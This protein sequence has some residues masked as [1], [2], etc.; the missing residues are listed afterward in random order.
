[1][2]KHAASQTSPVEALG[3]NPTSPPTQQELFGALFSLFVANRTPKQQVHSGIIFRTYYTLSY[4]HTYYWTLSYRIKS[5][6]GHLTCPSL[7]LAT[8]LQNRV[9]LTIE[10]SKLFPFDHLAISKGGFAFL[11]SDFADVINTCQPSSPS[12]LTLRRPPPSLCISPARPADRI[13]SA[14]RACGGARAH[15]TSYA[16][17]RR[18]YSMPG[19]RHWPAAEQ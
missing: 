4:T 3:K 16:G 2:G 19:R 11:K 14:A 7:I 8:Q 10:L 12:P 6:F 5:I 18:T 15:P 17:P 9:S 13:G 1:M